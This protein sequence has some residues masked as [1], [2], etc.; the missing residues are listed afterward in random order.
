MYCSL[1]QDAGLTVTT[2]MVALFVEVAHCSSHLYS[3][4]G[5][6][7]TVCTGSLGL[8]LILIFGVL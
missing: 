1:Y 5:M 6:G 8:L 2:E 3:V 4:N 7:G